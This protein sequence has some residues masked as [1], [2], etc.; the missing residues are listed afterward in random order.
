MCADFNPIGF[1][2]PVVDGPGRDAVSLTFAHPAEKLI[3]AFGSK[4]LRRN[5]IR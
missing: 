3:I 1:L 4:K 2:R 5:R